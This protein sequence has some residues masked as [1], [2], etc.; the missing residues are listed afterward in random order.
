MQLFDLI[1]QVDVRR[2]F[3]TSLAELTEEKKRSTGNSV[4]KRRL[5]KRSTTATSANVDIIDE[6]SLLKDV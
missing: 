5:T 4:K 2:H 6:M 1:G 3:Q